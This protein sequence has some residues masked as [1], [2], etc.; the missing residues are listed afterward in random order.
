MATAKL[1]QQRLSR[2]KQP[3]QPSVSVNDQGHLTT[4]HLC[5]ALRSPI[6]GKPCL[7]VQSL[8]ESQRTPSISSE[9]LAVP[10][11]HNSYKKFD[12]TAEKQTRAIHSTVHA[13]PHDRLPEGNTI[14]PLGF[15]TEEVE[16][17][18]RA[19]RQ[20]IDDRQQGDPS[21]GH[22]RQT[23]ALFLLAPTADRLKSG[24]GMPLAKRCRPLDYFAA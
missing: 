11:N 9:P 6:Q 24:V 23:I 7:E 19:D 13:L 16:V 8:S 5:R 14:A 18:P 15:E 17:R 1:N 3:S 20:W 4:Q 21:R 22:Q 10:T 12:N 2:E